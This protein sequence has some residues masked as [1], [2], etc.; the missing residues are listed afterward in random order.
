MLTPLR[1]ESM[2]PGGRGK[3][4]VG[5]IAD[6]SFFWAGRIG[7]PSYWVIDFGRSPYDSFKRK[8]SKIGRKANV[9][10]KDME[11][12][13]VKYATPQ[14]MRRAFAFHWSTRVMPAV[15]K[16]L[17]RHADISTTMNFF[18]TQNE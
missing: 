13:K 1:V 12:G 9:K 17:M 11:T 14:D 3:L 4:T 7:N 10:V 2:A 5:R 18:V 6:P 15:L 16:E 8:L